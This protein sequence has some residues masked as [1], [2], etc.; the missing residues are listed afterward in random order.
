MH[1]KQPSELAL[2]HASTDAADAACENDKGGQEEQEEGQ[3]Q[4][5]KY[6]HLAGYSILT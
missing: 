1:P 6:M 4:N 3:E 5:S 2:V